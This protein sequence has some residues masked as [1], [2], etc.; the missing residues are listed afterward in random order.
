MENNNQPQKP[1]SDILKP[2]QDQKNIEE[3]ATEFINER[4]AEVTGF[5]IEKLEFKDNFVNFVG[6][7]PETIELAN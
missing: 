2:D 1:S 4:M 7:Y 3:A 6:T 5:S